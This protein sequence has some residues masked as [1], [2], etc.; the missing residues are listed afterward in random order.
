LRFRLVTL[1]VLTALS[2]TL[3]ASAAPGQPRMTFASPVT[4]LALDHGSLW[5]SIAGDGVVS[6]TGPAGSGGSTHGA[7]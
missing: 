2:V 5:V 4:G 6:V 7:P 3:A 1:T